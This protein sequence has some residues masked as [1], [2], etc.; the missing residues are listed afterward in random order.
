MFIVNTRILLEEEKS[1]NETFALITSGHIM[2]PT[3]ECSD[4]LKLIPLFNPQ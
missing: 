1:T 2:V 3:T 4:Q